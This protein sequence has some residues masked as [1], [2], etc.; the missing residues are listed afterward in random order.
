MTTELTTS[1]N[2]QNVYYQT[3]S[4]VISTESELMFSIDCPPNTVLD[5]DVLIRYTVTFTDLK[6]PPDGWGSQFEGNA[7][8]DGTDVSLQDRGARATPN[9]D[10]PIVAFEQAFPMAHAM[11]EVKLEINGEK[12]IQNPSLYVPAMARFYSSEEEIQNVCSMAGGGTLNSG[13]FNAIGKDQMHLVSG[14]LTDLGAVIWR[15]VPASGSTISIQLNVAETFSSLP[16]VSFADETATIVANRPRLDELYNA[17]LTKRWRH[18]AYLSRTLDEAAT[19]NESLQEG[20]SRYTNAAGDK[21]MTFTITERLPFTPFMTWKARDRKLSVIPNLRK[22]AFTIKWHQQAWERFLLVNEQPREGSIS[23]FEDSFTV[24][25]Y[26][27]P[28]VLLTKWIVP[29]ELSK[30][31]PTVSVPWTHYET[32]T[33]PINGVTVPSTDKRTA[34]I[35]VSFTVRMARLPPKLFIFAK[36]VTDP[37]SG[38]TDAGEHNLEIVTLDLDID[39]Q[40][41]RSRRMESEM[42]FSLYTK[43]SPV[44]RDRPFKYIEWQRRYCTVCLSRSDIGFDIKQKGGTTLV[45]NLQLRSWWNTV[46]T[47]TFEG[48]SIRD[49]NEQYA[50]TVMGEFEYQMR[51]NKLLSELNRV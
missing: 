6:N 14:I 2:I 50:L 5:S 35:N 13:S 30:L 46:T 42:M 43:N 15:T 39:G 45:L 33:T 8:V 48:L 47:G 34:L 37:G 18:L 44:S 23:P 20:K 49:N 19:A 1:G 31:P 36:L 3:Y 9:A 26:S 32:Y 28:P 25:W 27:T 17:G 24:D 4:P 22:L 7:L 51:M 38:P 41:G 16:T 10:T 21:T 11:E 29:S 40:Q 12:I